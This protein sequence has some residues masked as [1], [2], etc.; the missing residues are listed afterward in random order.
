MGEIDGIFEGGFFGAAGVPGDVNTAFGG[1]FEAGDAL[2]GAEQV[3]GR[4]CEEGGGEGEEEKKMAGTRHRKIAAIVSSLAVSGVSG[5]V[6]GVQEAD[7]RIAEV[8]RLTLGRLPEAE[9]VRAARASL[10]QMLFARNEFLY[11]E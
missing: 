6:G 10:G 9:E 2:P 8:W 1:D 4:G 5:R 3:S 11:L 7:G